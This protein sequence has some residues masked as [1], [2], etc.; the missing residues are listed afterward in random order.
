[1]DPSRTAFKQVLYMQARLS[2][3][4]R[5]WCACI[6]AVSHK[7]EHEHRCSGP[8]SCLLTACFARGTASHGLPCSN[9]NTSTGIC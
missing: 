4:I 1:M 7:S 6:H 3:R 9:L 5:M 8:L 2:H